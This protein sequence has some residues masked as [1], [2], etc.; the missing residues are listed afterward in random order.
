MARGRV[1]IRQVAE[2]A[3]VSPTTVSHALN[4]KGRVTTETRE[5][6]QR[7]AAELGYRPNASARNLV[8]GRTGLLGLVVPPTDELLFLASDVA[9]FVQ[10]TNAATNVA[11]KQGYGLVV[12]TVP[13]DRSSPF[14]QVEVDGAIVVDPL[15]RDPLVLELRAAGVPVVTTGRVLGDEEDGVWVDNDHRASTRLVLDH[16]ARHGSRCPALLT[17]QP[18]TSFA[19]EVEETYAAWCAEHAVEPHLVHVRA[20]ISEDAAAEAARRVLDLRPTCDAAYATL[21]RLALA[22]LHE[23]TRRNVAVPE[24]FLIAGATDSEA[25]RWSLPSLTVLNLQPDALGRSATEALIALVEGREP[26]PRQR[27]VPCEVIA[28][29]STRRR[30]A[31]RRPAATAIR[32]ES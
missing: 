21:D 17:N 5:R 1:G 32:V 23:A 29:A 26:D 9:Y 10:I 27:T 12:T 8:G 28:R 6:I 2:A 3:G 18:S 14:G 16:L 19:F 13:E 11:M 25:A 4:G 7:I 15:E 20:G 31:G 22:T 24:E 30:P